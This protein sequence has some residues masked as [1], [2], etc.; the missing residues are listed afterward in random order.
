MS[1]RPRIAVEGNPHPNI[2]KLGRALLL[3]ES[4]QQSQRRQES[5]R[6]KPKGKQT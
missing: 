2:R 5:P 4:E 1:G 6:S 3:L